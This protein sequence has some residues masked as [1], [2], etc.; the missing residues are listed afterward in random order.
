MLC[1]S[2]AAATSAAVPAMLAL[3]YLTPKVAGSRLLIQHAAVIGISKGLEGIYQFPYM[4][5]QGTALPFISSEEKLK[6]LFRLHVVRVSI[7]APFIYN[8]DG[9]DE[10]SN[11]T[12]SV[13][14]ERN[15]K[16][17]A[18]KEVKATIPNE[19]PSSSSI[20]TFDFNE[21][22]SLVR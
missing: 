4:T 19:A 7:A 11:T 14:I 1:A 9:R 3:P 18:T 20:Q 13:C 15:G 5:V 12:Y 8:G 21:T 16:F 2:H 10:L 22:I 17:Q 6:L